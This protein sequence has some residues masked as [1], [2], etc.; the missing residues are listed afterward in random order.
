MNRRGFTLIEVMLALVIFMVVLLGV[1]QMT[2][3][4]VHTV[5]T[6]ERQEAAVQLAHDRL[7]L[8]QATPRYAALESLYVATETTFPT[9]PGFTRVTQVVRSGGP[10]QPMDHKTVT[11]TVT[12]P[13]LLVPVSRTITVAAP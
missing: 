1:G 2:A 9:L 12:G 10:G 3:S 7:A 8:V 4:M 5:A 13:G 11:V 6:S